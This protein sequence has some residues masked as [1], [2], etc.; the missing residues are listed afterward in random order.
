MRVYICF[1][2]HFCVRLCVCTSVCVFVHVYVCVCVC[3]C[4]CVCAVCICVC[5]CVCVCVQVLWSLGNYTHNSLHYYTEIYS[6]L[7]HN[8]IS[9]VLNCIKI[10]TL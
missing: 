7:S 5:V 2:V 8:N 10:D 9:D 6:A 3:L 1:S 4:V